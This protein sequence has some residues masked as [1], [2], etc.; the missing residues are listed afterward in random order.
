[1]YYNG[2]QS[3]K[4]SCVK[5]KHGY[6]IHAEKLK[7][8]LMD[9]YRTDQREYVSLSLLGRYGGKSEDVSHSLP[10]YLQTQ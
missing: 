5:G 10:L 3:Y 4:K 7:Y 6:G 9:L 8:P 2:R 1:M